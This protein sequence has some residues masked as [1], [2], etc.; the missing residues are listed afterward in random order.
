MNEEQAYKHN[1]SQT[2]KIFMFF[3]P[4]V[5]INFVSKTYQHI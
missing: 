3:D 1:Q 5:G 2:G 4:S